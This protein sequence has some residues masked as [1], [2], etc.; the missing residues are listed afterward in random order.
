MATRADHVILSRAGMGRN[1]FVALLAVIVSALLSVTTVEWTN[2]AETDEL[3]QLRRELEEQRKNTEALEKRLREL[4]AK[5]KERAVELEAK[6]KEPGF[7]VK[8]DNGFSVRSPDNRFSLTVNGL[9]QARYTLLA[10]EEGKTNHNFDVALGR[11]AF[12]GSVFDPDLMYF[13]QLHGSTLGNSNG[14]SLLDWWLK[15]RLLPDVSVQGGRFV[16]PYSRQFYTHPGNLLFPDLSEADLA[17]NLPR[18]IGVHAAA[19]LGRLSFHAAVLN[20]I[21][22]LDGAGQQN[23][24]DKIA[25]LGRVELAILEPYGY[26]ESSPKMVSAPQL[27]LGLA[28]AFNPIDEVSAL[29]NVVPGDQTTNVTV[30]AGFRW[31]LLTLQAAGYYRRNDF[32]GSGRPAA[33]DWG[34]YGQIGYYLVPERWELAARISGVDFARLNAPG[35]LGDTTAYSLGLNYYLYGHNAKLQGDYSFLDL[36]PFQGPHRHDNRVRLQAQVLF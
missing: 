17:F 3:R 31:Q 10:P 29:Q 11:L 27:S 12:S 4:E 33:N 36:A 8:Y 30:D 5:E 35:T 20:S 2:A 28:A 1:T 13:M 26:L 9:V 18:G 23:L 22:A 16:L 6:Q 7:E 14:V 19:G 32:K 21:R 24:N 15:Y 25:G 34:Y